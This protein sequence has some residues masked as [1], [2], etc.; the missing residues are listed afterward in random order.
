MTTGIRAYAFADE[1]F[2]HDGYYWGPVSGILVMHT[3]RA[4]P[5][6]NR[7]EAKQRTYRKDSFTL[8]GFALALWVPEF[9]AP[10]SRE[11]ALWFIGNAMKPDVA[12][13]MVPERAPRA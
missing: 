12:F 7:I 11:L 10:D 3:K 6:Q 4:V 5:A 13:A 2:E 9:L 1:F 8:G